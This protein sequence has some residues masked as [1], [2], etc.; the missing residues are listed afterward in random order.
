MFC[1]ECAAA[2]P[3]NAKFCPE[4]A[5]P[6]SN[7][8]FNARPAQVTTIP[9]PP[10]APPQSRQP[11]TAKSNNV[12]KMLASSFAVVAILIV[13]TLTFLRFSISP[14]PQNYYNPNAANKQ[15]TNA[16]ATAE[17]PAPKQKRRQKQAVVEAPATQTEPTATQPTKMEIVNKSFNVVAGRYEYFTFTVGQD[18]RIVGTFQARGGSKNDIQCLLIRSDDLIN[19]MNG[20]KVQ[21]YYG[22][23]TTYGKIDRQI[24]TGEYALVFSNSMAFVSDKGVGANIWVEY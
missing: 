18:S 10:T 17:A 8:F 7:S 19:L 23:T 9:D 20:H 1:T 21:T 6:A 11:P 4:C 16:P 14:A 13:A 3:P 2:L 15:L 24:P 22:E 5:A 12:K